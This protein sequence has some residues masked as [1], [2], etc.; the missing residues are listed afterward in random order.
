LT[1]LFI[2]AS[3]EAGDDGVMVR[4]TDR[5]KCGRCWRHLPEVA[6]DASYLA[7][8]QRIVIF[9]L[10]SVYSMLQYNYTSV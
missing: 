7:A 1:E 9:S 8:P 3:V 5:R 6:Q 4:P 2:V 10:R